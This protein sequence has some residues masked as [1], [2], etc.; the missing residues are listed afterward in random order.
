MS[1]A[2][3]V[4]WSDRCLL[5]EPAGE[6]WI[7]LR[8]EGTEVPARAE[9]IRDALLER[10]APLV[11]ARSHPDD[12]LTRIHDSGLVA[13]LETA[14]DEWAAAGLPEDPGQDRVVPYVFAHSS[15]GARRVPAAAWA[16]PGYYA[17]DTMTLVGPGTWEAA[18]AA[19]AAALP[20]IR[21][22]VAA[23]APP[24]RRWRCP[25]RAGRG[26]SRRGCVRKL[27][28]EKPG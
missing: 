21:R 28:A 26:R 8:T 7:G 24:A 27:P 17:Y 15:L 4:V 12:A 23:A 3:S 22:S 2:L 1:L 18:R 19:V 6:V 13:Y 9:R 5:H 25:G 16:R 14:W 11:A 10:G 20:A